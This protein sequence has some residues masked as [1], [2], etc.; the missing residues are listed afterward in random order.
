MLIHSLFP[1]LRQKYVDVCCGNPQELFLQIVQTQLAR[2]G[3]AC[4]ITPTLVEP[5]IL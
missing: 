3:R 1:A 5:K 2:A 4:K